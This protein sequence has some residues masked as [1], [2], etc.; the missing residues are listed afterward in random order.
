MKKLVRDHRTIGVEIARNEIQVE[1]KA[2]TVVV[3]QTE[4]EGAPQVLLGNS[5]FVSVTE[6]DAEK[7][8]VNKM[9]QIMSQAL[10]FGIDSETLQELA[11]EALKRS[12]RYSESISHNEKVLTS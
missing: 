8:F 3:Y 12:E 6:A 7:Y 5:G 4:P 1:G 2:V 11:N 10:Y 9:F